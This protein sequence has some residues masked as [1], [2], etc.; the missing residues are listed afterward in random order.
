MFKVRKDSENI[1]IHQ[2]ILSSRLF[3]IGIARVYGLLSA[4]EVCGRWRGLPL[5]V[6]ERVVK[7]IMLYKTKK[8]E[9]FSNEQSQVVTRVTS[10][11]IIRVIIS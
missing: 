9:Y 5:V 1:Y 11:N 6:T 8:E 2:R 7:M 3:V 10:L 4:R